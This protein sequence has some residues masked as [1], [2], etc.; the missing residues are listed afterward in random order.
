M[1]GDRIRVHT[2]RAHKSIYARSRLVEEGHVLFFIAACVGFR[3]DCRKPLG[4][5]R[6]ERFWSGTITPDEWACYYAMVL[7]DHDMDFAAIQDDAEV[8]AHIEEYAN[9]GVG[10]LL[11]ECLDSFVSDDDSTPTINPRDLGEA[12]NAMLQYLFN[13][14]EK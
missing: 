9:A 4:K 8:I 6:D 7:K 14:S 5:A 1:M 10:V 11:N 12:G 13:F 2:D 3:R